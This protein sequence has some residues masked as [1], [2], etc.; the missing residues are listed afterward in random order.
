MRW[1]SL[2]HTKANGGMGFKDMSLFNQ[3]MLGR[4]GWRLITRPEA[5][6]SRVLKGKYYLNS[7]FLAATRTRKSSEM[8][9]A[10]RHG[11][12]VLKKGMVYRIDPGTSVNIWKDNW[13]PG[14]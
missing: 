7:V 10:I 2:T 9:R 3:A 14:I 8:W 13:I 4:Q 11:R 1:S 6:C 12:E 5:L